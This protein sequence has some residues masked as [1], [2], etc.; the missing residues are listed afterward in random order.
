MYCVSTVANKLLEDNPSDS[1]DV[2]IDA[3]TIVLLHSV[4]LFL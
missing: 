2:G 1:M 4:I 3:V